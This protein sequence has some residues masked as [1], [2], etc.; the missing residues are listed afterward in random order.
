MNQP[1]ANTQPISNKSDAETM[2]APTQP[3]KKDVGKPRF[4]QYMEVPSQYGEVDEQTLRDRIPPLRKAYLN[5]RERLETATRE[6]ERLRKAVSA[7]EAQ[8]KETDA[9][10]RRDFLNG[11]GK[12]SKAVRDQLKQKANWQIEAEQQREMIELLEPQV[13]W[14]R[15]HTHYARIEFGSAQG[16]LYHYVAHKT[17]LA[18]AKEFAESDIAEKLYETLPALFSRIEIEL[19]N[20]DLNSQQLKRL[21]YAAIGELL[22]SYRPEKLPKIQVDDAEKYPK[23]DF[24]AD[25]SEFRSFLG[26]RKRVTDAEEKMDII[27]NLEE[28]DKA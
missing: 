28:I 7:L 3:V 24:E 18:V 19:S 4:L 6:L 2:N 12:Q 5:R 9:S 17:M 27:P 1:A 8:E 15:V 10:W 21:Q 11:F 14:L 16:H 22:L 23:M 13:A 26:V 20:R 25:P